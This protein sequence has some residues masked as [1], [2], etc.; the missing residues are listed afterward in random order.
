MRMKFL[1]ILPET[2]AITSPPMSSSTRNCVLASASL[3]RPSTSIASSFAI[4]PPVK[5]EYCSVETPVE[6]SRWRKPLLKQSTRRQ[7]T[8][9][10]N[11]AA[12]DS[13]WVNFTQKRRR[14]RRT[15]RSA[16]RVCY[17]TRNP[18][19]RKW[20]SGLV[21]ITATTVATAISTAA[22]TA[23]AAPPAPSAT[24]TTTATATTTAAAAVTTFARFCDIHCQRPPVELLVIQGSDGRLRLCLVGH[25]D[26]AKSSRSAGFPIR[27]HLRACDGPV[28]LEHRVQF[29]RCR[30]PGKIADVD[31]RSH[32]TA[33]AT[34]RLCRQRPSVPFERR[35]RR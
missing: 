21:A 11:R 19:K 23:V 24:V 3:T 12:P 29:V 14:A 22:T 26:E 35:N 13:N 6:V 20:D 33:K 15:F 8:R 10:F 30:G 27:D 1:R 2:C 25:F 7:P 18:N 28:L 4:Y 17:C 32:A 31:V 9:G 16:G 34:V 5:G